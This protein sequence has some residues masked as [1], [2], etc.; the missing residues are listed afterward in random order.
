MQIDFLCATLCGQFNHRHDVIFVAMDATGREQT[1][2]VHGFTGVFRLVNRCGQ[3]RVSKE[4]TFFNF[5]VQTGQVLIHDAARAQVN[6]TDFGVTHLTIGQA[7]FQTGSID[8][9]MRAFCP[10]RIHYRGFGSKNGV[11]LAV[12][13]VAIAIQNHQYHRF[14]RNRHCETSHSRDKNNCVILLQLNR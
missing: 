6:V 3:R 1:H 5:N 7:H 8:Q 13:T 4:S 10:Q 14:F 12:F 2:D 9:G 11:I